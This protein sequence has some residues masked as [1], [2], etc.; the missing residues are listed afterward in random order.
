MARAVTVSCG[1]FSVCNVA[2]Q[3]APSRLGGD[4]ARAGADYG[5]AFGGVQRVQHHQPAV[6]DPAV[7]IGEAAAIGM[8]ECRRRG[9]RAE[10]HR[11]G[12][13]QAPAP[14]E[15]VVQEQAGANHPGRALLGRM[16]EHE[17][18]WP[19][20]VRGDGQQA[21]ALPQGFAD[22]AEFIIFQVAQPAM[23]QLGAGG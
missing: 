18:Q 23:H 7:G 2:C 3:S 17:F 9:V 11:A 4:Q 22:Q 1:P 13:R 6:V 15:M 5:A 21:L 12:G 14:G 16:R 8:F 20:D 19:D 10:P